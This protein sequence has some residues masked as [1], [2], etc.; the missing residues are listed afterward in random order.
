[1]KTTR[2]EFTKTFTGAVVAASFARAGEPARLPIA[3]STLGCPAWD[4][5]KILNFA[6]QHVL[7][8]RIPRIARQSGFAF[9]R[10]ICNRPYR[11][12]E[13]RDSVSRPSR[14]LCQQLRQP[15]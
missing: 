15:A 3:F 12:D 14:C 5:Q 8:R 7:R 9:S 10:G 13:T 1:M 11:R 6:E 4:L 2:R